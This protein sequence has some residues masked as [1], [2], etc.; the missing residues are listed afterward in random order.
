M[1]A[2]GDIAWRERQPDGTIDV[3]DYNTSPEAKAL[4]INVCVTYGIPIIDVFRIEFDDTEAVVHRFEIDADGRRFVRD[5]DIAAVVTR[6]LW[7][8]P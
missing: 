2:A 1:S 4:A 8:R 5:G 7:T 6:H 3:E